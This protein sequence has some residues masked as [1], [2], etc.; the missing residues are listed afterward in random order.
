VCISLGVYLIGVHLMNVHLTGVHLRGVYL[1]GVH[2]IDL[3]FMDVYKSKKALEKTS[4]SPILQTMVDLSR[5]ELQ[6]TLTSCGG[7]CPIAL[8]ARTIS[9]AKAAKSATQRD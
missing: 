4:R 5:S 9:A 3:Y 2:L 8:R 6:N 7:W 1:M